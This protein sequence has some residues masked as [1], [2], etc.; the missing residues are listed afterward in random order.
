MPSSCLPGPTNWQSI[1]RIDFLTVANFLS[2]SRSLLA[3][4]KNN[5]H[6]S[7]YYELL[8]FII[9]III[10]IIIIIIIIIIVIII[11][12]IPF[13]LV[14]L[15]YYKDLSHLI[16]LSCNYRDIHNNRIVNIGQSCFGSLPKLASLWVN[17][18]S[19]TVYF[20][21]RD[22]VVFLHFCYG[23]NGR[24]QQP[25]PKLLGHMWLKIICWLVYFCQEWV[26]QSK[27]QHCTGEVGGVEGIWDL[28]SSGADCLRELF[29]KCKWR[30]RK[31]WCK[32]SGGATVSY[33]CSIWHYT[34]CFAM[35]PF[36]LE[37]W[38]WELFKSRRKCLGCS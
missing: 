7:Y 9:I 13:T 26:K 21:F 10:N 12:I 1:S 4:T 15:S 37:C 31:V 32:M 28:A 38:G 23:N 35:E 33:F 2:S 8:S 14:A 24:H 11:I 25:T 16:F 22:C 6:D 5:K 34:L 30:C 17:E 19:T 27:F 3:F 20:W 18:F 36:L 29:K